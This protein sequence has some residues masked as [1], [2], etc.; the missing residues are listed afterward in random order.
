MVPKAK[1]PETVDQARV[2]DGRRKFILAL[3]VVV[4]F[5]IFQAVLIKVPVPDSNREL[6]AQAMGA[7]QGVIAV[8]IG[9]Y[10]ALRNGSN[11]ERAIETLA[12][13]VP[14]PTGEAAAPT[15]QP[16]TTD[17]LSGDPGQTEDRRVQP[18]PA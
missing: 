18:G 11:N 1:P 4:G 5:L 14:P 13:K 6:V 8:V 12:D 10:F 7:L 3:I 9:A 15:P 2:E 16:E 17:E